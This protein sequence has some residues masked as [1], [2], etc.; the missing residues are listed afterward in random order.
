MKLLTAC[1]SVFAVFAAALAV[2]LG[3]RRLVPLLAKWWPW[4]EALGDW[5][6]KRRKRRKACK[7]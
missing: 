1:V 3:V 5:L 4:L 6:W 2:A 7:K